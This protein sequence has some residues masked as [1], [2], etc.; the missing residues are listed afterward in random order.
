MRP[1]SLR[2]EPP[3]I[4]LP[5]E[6]HAQFG[7]RDTILISWDDQGNNS[8]RSSLDCCGGNALK[9]RARIALYRRRRHG[10]AVA[11]MVDSSLI[12]CEKPYVR[13]LFRLRCSPAS[14]VPTVLYPIVNCMTSPVNSCFRPFCR[15]V[16]CRAGFAVLCA[17]ASAAE[18]LASVDTPPPAVSDAI[19]TPPAPPDA[20]RQR[21]GRFRCPPRSPFLYAIPATGRRP[22][23]F[24][25][26]GCPPGSR[27]TPRRAA[28]PAVSR[29]PV[30]TT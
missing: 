11:S 18:N 22:L 24:A 5:R 8:R 7:L 17:F 3:F 6:C 29:R 30:N 19:L 1:P 27:S 14:N 21:S 20:P 26:Q 15:I 9:L 23:T 12:L 28:S 13:R 10:V 2:D 4:G 16:L 25:V